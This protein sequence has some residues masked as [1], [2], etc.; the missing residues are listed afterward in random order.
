MFETKE[1]DADRLMQRNCGMPMPLAKSLSNAS[2]R[3]TK[4][5]EWHRQTLQRG[6]HT[7]EDRKVSQVTLPHKLLL[8]KLL[9]HTSPATGQ[10]WRTCGV[11]CRT[12]KLLIIRGEICQN[13]FVQVIY[14]LK[15]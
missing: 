15:V 9:P 7:V 10:C 13:G 1:I 8:R 12:L 4:C 11:C 3:G 2:L 6:G 14:N 5:L